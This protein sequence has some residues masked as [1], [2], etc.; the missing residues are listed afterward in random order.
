MA[1][2]TI[3]IDD[4]DLVKAQ[5][6]I[7]AKV[8]VLDDINEHKFRK[9]FDSDNKS[10]YPNFTGRRGQ[11]TNGEVYLA[12]GMS[13]AEIREEFPGALIKIENGVK[14]FRLTKVNEEYILPKV[15]SKWNT[16]VTLPNGQEERQI[17]ELLPE[18]KTITKETTPKYKITEQRLQDVVKFVDPWTL[19][20]WTMALEDENG[21][22]YSDRYYQLQNEYYDNGGTGDPLE[23]ILNKDFELVERGTHS[24]LKFPIWSNTK[25]FDV[26][27]FNKKNKE[28]DGLEM[29]YDPE[30]KLAGYGF[31]RNLEDSDIIEIYK[32]KTNKTTITTIDQD[33]VKRNKFIKEM[34]DANRIANIVNAGQN[35]TWN[36][37]YQQG[38]PTGLTIIIDDEQFKKGGQIHIK[39]KNKG[40]FTKQAQSAGMSVQEFARHVL[41]HKDRYPASTVKRANFARNATKFN[42]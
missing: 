17:K 12:N 30:A 29:K 34:N 3:Y 28:V 2:L 24:Q 25:N 39:E 23:Y 18:T 16:V 10:W 22:P 42:H 1:G 40:K 31:G 15:E 37:Q 36:L 38:G 11:D 21:K 9:L 5:K 6:G 33:A 8:D 27:Y 41:A 26:I 7:Q 20:K 35:R 32:P 14:T 19:P 4:K 13:N